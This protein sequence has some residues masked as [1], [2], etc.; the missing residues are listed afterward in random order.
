MRWVFSLIIVVLILASN[1]MFVRPRENPSDSAWLLQELTTEE[2]LRDV[3]RQGALQVTPTRV[4]V[5]ETVEVTVEENSGN[6]SR[7]L[8]M[9]DS[10]GE[11]MLDDAR[12]DPLRTQVFQIAR[13]APIGDYRF[14]LAEASL[15]A[16]K[17][18]GVITVEVYD[19]IPGNLRRA[20]QLEVIQTF[21][22]A[23]QNGDEELAAL[24]FVSGTFDDQTG[25]QAQRD[26]VWPV[27]ELGW[28]GGALLYESPDPKGTGRWM[29]QVDLQVSYPQGMEAS[30]FW[31]NYAS[32]RYP[33]VVWT[34]D[35]WRIESWNSDWPQ[36]FAVYRPRQ[37]E[38]VHVSPPENQPDETGASVTTE[39][40]RAASD[41]EGAGG[42]NRVDQPVH[43]PLD[44]EGEEGL[45]S[46]STEIGTGTEEVGANDAGGD[47]AV[48]IGNEASSEADGDEVDA[49]D[50]ARAEGNPVET[51]P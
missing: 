43:A 20:S 46:R 31:G 19:P 5:G 36:E 22:A 3:K 44:D 4:A 34:L 24:C 28:R 10:N 12:Y 21:V 16:D 39:S 15:R 1:A 8:V 45:E 27:P 11:H 25:G 6:V 38:A 29:L 41:I 18:L 50:S 49:A 30:A 35:G 13:T 51:G 42:A 23:A 7:A 47:D 14:W 40:Y 33:V 37:T 17:G 9:I 26:A 32:V 2:P 48:T